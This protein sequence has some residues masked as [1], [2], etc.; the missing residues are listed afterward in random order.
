VI[1]GHIVGMLLELVHFD[2]WDSTKTLGHF[3]E[4]LLWTNMEVHVALNGGKIIYRHLPV[5]S[6]IYHPLEVVHAR[7]LA[8]RGTHSFKEG[9]ITCLS[10]KSQATCTRD[11]Q[12]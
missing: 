7:S 6:F 10:A 11:T 5:V 9:K 1:V 12:F 4:T 2:D 8:K 3:D